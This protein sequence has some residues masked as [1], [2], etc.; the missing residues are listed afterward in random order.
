VS[1]AAKISR[2]AVGP[3]TA[4]LDVTWTVKG[5]L[6]QTVALDGLPLERAAAR[7]SA[8]TS[9]RREYLIKLS[10]AKLSFGQVFGEGAER[11]ELEVTSTAARQVVQTRRSGM[12]FMREIPGS[13]S[14]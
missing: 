13:R 6:T 7:Q 1:A 2:L 9:R 8:T 12:F 4:P 14:S 10:L 3:E 11:Q 5:D